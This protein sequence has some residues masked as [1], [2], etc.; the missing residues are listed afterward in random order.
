MTY[1]MPQEIRNAIINSSNE[2]IQEKLDENFPSLI[3]QT[4]TSDRKQ[5]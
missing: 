2:V 1:G 4:G 5:T 3:F